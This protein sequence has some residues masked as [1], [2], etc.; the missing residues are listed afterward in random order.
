MKRSLLVSGF[1][2]VL[3]VPYSLNA[4]QRFTCSLAPV[5][6]D[7]FYQVVLSPMITARTRFDYGDLRVLDKQGKEVPFILSPI[8][9][10]PI[11][12]TRWIPVPDPKV[13]QYD[14]SNKNTYVQLR[15]DQ[16]YIIDKIRLHVSGPRFYNRR[17]YL[18]AEHFNHQPA[19]LSSRQDNSYELKVKQQLVT[20]TIYNGDNPPVKID[21]VTALQLYRSIVSYLKKGDDYRL[22]FG[23]SLLPAP[24][25]D[26]EFFKDSIQGAIEIGTGPI[27]PLQSVGPVAQPGK[28][29]LSK[30]WMWVMIAAALAILLFFTLRMTRE[31]KRREKQE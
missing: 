11:K 1:A 27:L 18:P 19:Y 25:Y 29:E 21:S 6:K 7:G 14:S 5:N 20:L 3:L 16:A 23:D 26:L 17:I 24:E 15:F 4:R 9:A 2:I 31:I 8:A 10:T 13:I 30:I 12:R 28:K 22:V